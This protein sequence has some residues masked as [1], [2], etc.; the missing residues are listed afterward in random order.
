MQKYGKDKNKG[1]SP[2]VCFGVGLG[3]DVT[4][5]NCVLGVTCRVGAKGNPFMQKRL[6]IFLY[7]VV[8]FL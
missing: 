7:A 6:L 5:G 1:R 3:F 8:V 4:R 2:K